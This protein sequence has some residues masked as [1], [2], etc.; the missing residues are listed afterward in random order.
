MKGLWMHMIRAVR[1]Q[2]K[3]VNWA[4]E[5]RREQTKTNFKIL[6]PTVPIK[7]PHSVPFCR[8]RSRIRLGSS[9]LTSEKSQN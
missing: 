9:C 8:L 3:L 5:F 1:T 2:V 7:V 4:G 6:I